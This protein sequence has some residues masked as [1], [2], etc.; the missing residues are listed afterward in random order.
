MARP[1]G[2]KRQAWYQGASAIALPNNH[3]RRE[4]RRSF[5]H[6]DGIVLHFYHMARPARA[7]AP[8]AATTR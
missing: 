3:E 4:L 7:Y 1:C 6:A 8:D 2:R 5:Q